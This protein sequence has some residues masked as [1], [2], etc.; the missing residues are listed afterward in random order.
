[1]DNIEYIDD[2]LTVTVNVG[3]IKKYIQKKAEELLEKRS[4]QIDKLILYKNL[5]HGNGFK[6][7]IIE[8]NENG[9]K[10]ETEFL[11]ATLASK[12][13]ENKYN[14]PLTISSFKGLKNR[15]DKE[16]SDI[17]TKLQQTFRGKVLKIE[18]LDKNP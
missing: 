13:L 3:E 2:D 10:I 1:M 4:T 17:K 5:S 6:Y 14:Y 12:Y 9:G 18:K 7:K 15:L 16:P 11:N 8:Q